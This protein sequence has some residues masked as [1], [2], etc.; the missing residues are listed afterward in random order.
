MSQQ[1]IFIAAL[2]AKRYIEWCWSVDGRNTAEEETLY[3][4]I[5]RHVVTDEPAQ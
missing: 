2:L 1:W 3:V 5:H 4:N